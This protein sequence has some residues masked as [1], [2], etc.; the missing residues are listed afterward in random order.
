MRMLLPRQSHIRA[1]STRKRGFHDAELRLQVLAN[2]CKL[3]QQVHIAAILLNIIVRKNVFM[4]GIGWIAVYA[5][6]EGWRALLRFKG[7]LS[8]KPTGFDYAL[9]ATTTALSAGLALFGAKLLLSSKN[10]MGLVCIGFGLLGVL[11]VRSARQR[12][13]NPPS[14]PQWLRLHIRM[15]TGAFSAALTAFL[16][17]QL[18]GHMG[19]F[20]WVV[21]V[22]PTLLMSRYG[23]YETERRGL[24]DP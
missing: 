12:W 22:A 1:P 13:I 24:T 2:A 15:M 16:A 19:G 10:I 17:L 18:S 11:F 7:K 23:T 4:L 6:S 20:E 9:A 5:G 14:K 8:A 3:A 21:W